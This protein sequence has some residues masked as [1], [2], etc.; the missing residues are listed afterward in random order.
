[1]IT[2][3]RDLKNHLV[4]TLLPWAR[5]LFTRP[6][7]SGPIQPGNACVYLNHW[8]Q[9]I[10]VLDTARFQTKQLDTMQMQVISR[11]NPRARTSNMKFYF[12]V[13]KILT[14][15]YLVSNQA[16]LPTTG[17]WLS[18]LRATGKSPTELSASLPSCWVAVQALVRQRRVCADRLG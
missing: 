18:T 1:M 12:W 17:C 2:I 14:G 8:Q 15:M 11:I 16:V 4:L 3:G 5:R 13:L 6:H 7:C 10:A 9:E